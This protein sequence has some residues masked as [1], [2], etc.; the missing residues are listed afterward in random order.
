MASFVFRTSR[1]TRSQLPV[2]KVPRDGGYL[3]SISSAR[4]YLEL[5]ETWILWATALLWQDCHT[6]DFVGYA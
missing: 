4:Y 1:T 3:E 6:L 2:H 5:C